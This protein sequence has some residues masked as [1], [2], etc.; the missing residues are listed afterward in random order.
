MTSFPHSAGF[1]I[2]LTVL[3]LAAM[4]LSCQPKS[5]DV[6]AQPPDAKPELNVEA[7][8]APIEDTTWRLAEVGGRPAETVPAD[9]RAAHLRLNASDHRAS[10]YTG[11]NSFN[12]TYTLTGQTLRFGPMAMTRRAGPEPL[13]RQEAAFGRALTDTASWRAA[14]ERLELLDASG[15]P[16]ATL[17]RSPAGQAP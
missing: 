12:G 7:K 14:G 8:P 10:G 16:L 5:K 2:I 6:D 15:K 9:A 11:V 17:T 3:T 1:R 4:A 13:N